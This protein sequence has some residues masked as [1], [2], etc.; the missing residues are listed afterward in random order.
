MSI[1]RVLLL[2]GAVCAGKSAVASLLESGERFSRLSTS[3]HLRAYANS[4][5][6]GGRFE[7]QELGDLRDAQTDFK[8]VVDDVA[9]PAVVAKPAA[10]DWLLDAARKPRQVMHLREFFGPMVRHVH[11]TAPEAT[12]I[13]RYTGRAR[14]GDK[15]YTETISHPNEQA[16][17]SLVGLA[18]LCIDTSHCT[19]EDAVARTLAL[20]EA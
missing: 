20:W 15:A 3:G 19:P 4:I 16:A 11:L 14:D 6:G 1:K 9:R 18:D 7:L 8:W 12:L 10:Q 13:E 2:S 5:D 17:R